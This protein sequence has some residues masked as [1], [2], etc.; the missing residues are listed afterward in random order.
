MPGVLAD[1]VFSA[2]TVTRALKKHRDGPVCSDKCRT[3][4]LRSEE[5]KHTKKLVYK[6]VILPPT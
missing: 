4:V 3:V 5:D 1:R 2:K 6:V